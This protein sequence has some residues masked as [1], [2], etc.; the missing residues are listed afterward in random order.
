MAEKAYHHGNLRNALIEAGIK[1]INDKGIHQ[2]SLRRVAVICEV[3]H[4]APYAH[5]KDIDSLLKA[6]SEHV[7]MQF[8]ETLNAVIEGREI[9]GRVITELGKAYVT[10]FIEHP[11][12]FQFLFDQSGIKID[13]DSEQSNDYPPFALF[14]DTA[15]QLFKN[16]NLPAQAQKQLLIALWAQ[17]HGIA[18]L[19]TN[20]NIRYSGDWTALMDTSMFLEGEQICV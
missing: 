8:T 18:A 13:L 9:G 3:S 15:Y 1:L 4:T 7:A 12:Y 20:G 19:A 6:M 14:R 17:V 16:L 11:N 2:F 5:F 10:F